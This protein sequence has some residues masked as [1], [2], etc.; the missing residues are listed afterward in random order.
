MFWTFSIEAVRTSKCSRETFRRAEVLTWQIDKL[1]LWHF[2]W[3][4]VGRL[5]SLRSACQV[6]HLPGRC[7]FT[8]SQRE[9]SSSTRMTSG[10]ISLFDTK[11]VFVERL[12]AL[13]IVS[14]A[15]PSVLIMTA[16][17]LNSFLLS[18]VQTKPYPHCAKI[19]TQRGLDNLR[20]EFALFC[21]FV[22]FFGP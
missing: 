12:F 2:N 18:P 11:F 17:T 21:L 20:D 14:A 4:P 6:H 13:G 10:Q 19:P 3:H 16:V 22:C 1:H 5:D 8:K 7:W 9:T 15:D